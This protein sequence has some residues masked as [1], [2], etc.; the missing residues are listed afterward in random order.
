MQKL[1]D[2]FEAY[3][4]EKQKVAALDFDDMLVETY[5]LLSENDEVRD[6]YK[7]TFRHL[8][9]D[10]WQDTNPLQLELLKILVNESDSGASF[11]VCGDDW[12]IIYAFTGASMNNILNFKDLFPGL[13]AADS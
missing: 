4:K 2:L 7:G 1:A 3:D 13:R 10:E 8:L 9:V 11:W 6:K 12:Q 5:R